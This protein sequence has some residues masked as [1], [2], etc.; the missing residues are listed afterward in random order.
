MVSDAIKFRN[1]N[2]QR[3]KEG[4]QRR[5]DFLKHAAIRTNQTQKAIC[6]SF[7]IH[8]D[9]LRNWRHTYPEFNHA[10]INLRR[11]K[12][13]PERNRKG[14]LMAKRDL[15]MD[16]VE[17]R[18]NYFGYE[19]PWFQLAT[20]DAYQRAKP[21]DIVF[22]L[23]PPEHGK[24]TLTEDD[25]TLAIAK[26]NNI[27]ITLVSEGER[28][29]QKM[30][31][32]IQRRLM[33]DG[34][35][36]D[37]VFDT[38]PYEPQEGQA[39]QQ[40]WGVKAWTVYGA[41]MSADQRDFTMAIGGWRSAIAGT[42]ANRLHL[43]DLQS[44]R[45]LGQ[46]EDMWMRFRQD[47]L[48]RPGETGITTANGTRVGPRDFYAR[49]DQEFRGEDF[50]QKIEF[51][52][53]VLDNDTQ[54]PKPLWEYDPKTGTG[55]TM[56]A[57]ER[58][59]KKVGEE[60]WWRNYMQ[61]PKSNELEVFS[62]KGIAKCQNPMRSYSMSKD[63]LPESE[64]RNG[65]CWITVDPSI[66]GR[67]IVAAMH[68]EADKLWVLA[69][70][71]DTGLP[72]NSA[73]AEVVDQVAGELKAK[74]WRPTMLVI[75]AMAFQKGLMEDEAINEVADRHGMRLESHLTGSNKYDEEVGIP[76]MASSV[77]SGLIDLPYADDTDRF[78]TD[79]LLSE[80][81]A[82]KPIRDKAT[83]RMKFQR[84]TQLRQDMLMALWFG[85]IWW[86]NLYAGSKADAVDM[87]QGIKFGGVPYGMTNTGFL[88]PN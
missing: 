35:F 20:V 42:R 84:G 49:V 9:T 81:R 48:S 15:A 8:I 82:W 87:S 3:K 78:K 47:M 53:I 12:D 68:P 72:R 28:M 7:G 44:L 22:V 56:E 34:P 69:M 30:S 32:R 38:G 62:E 54:E 6:E 39:Q 13:S 58:L 63:Q 41:N 66:G 31:S 83:G 19:T 33:A 86:I 25:L 27:M 77:E 1:V 75:E 61:N 73:I 50:Y 4:E 36:P 67:N 23:M 74:G 40:P 21:G 51:P 10:F 14:G 18:F 52:A 55:Y 17:A 5:Q 70:R 29:A 65:E 11:A 46:T 2:R 43:D 79:L 64:V 37:L 88:L 57:L 85:W 71:E 24:T 60:A 16:F 80:F 45:S 76:S 26:N 59:R